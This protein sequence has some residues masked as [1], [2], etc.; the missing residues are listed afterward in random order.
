MKINPFSL[1]VFCLLITSPFALRSQDVQRDKD[2]FE[3]F[4]YQEGDTTWTMK[5]YYFCVLK[6]GP[7]RSQSAEEASEIQAGHMAHL[8]KLGDDKKICMAG[9]FGGHDTWRGIVVFNT[10]TKEEAEELMSQDPAVKAG[11][12]TYEIVDWWAAKGT[13]LF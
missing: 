2:G 8:G 7:N 3:I 9:P 13:K 6:A 10:T 11:R 4:E 12:L 5:K 1:F